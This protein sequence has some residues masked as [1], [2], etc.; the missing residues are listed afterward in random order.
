MGSDLQGPDD[1]GRRDR[2]TRPPLDDPRPDWTEHPQPG[3]ESQEGKLD[4]EEGTNHTLDN[5][6]PATATMNWRPTTTGEQRLAICG[7]LRGGRDLW[8]VPLDPP[9]RLAA[10]GSRPL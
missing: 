4:E 7:G 1:D 5:N 6:E 8:R 9:L 3:G 2:P 10:G